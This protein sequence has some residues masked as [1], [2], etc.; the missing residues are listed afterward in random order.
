MFLTFF[1]AF[2][3][4]V[5]FGLFNGLVLLPVLL[6]YVGPSDNSKDSPA[7]STSSLEF[8]KDS[9]IG[10]RNMGFIIDK[11]IQNENVDLQSSKGI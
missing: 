7:V 11:D 1:K 5:V 6:S 2:T 8:R 10:D 9:I 3:L 4:T